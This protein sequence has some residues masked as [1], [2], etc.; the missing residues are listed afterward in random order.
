MSLSDADLLKKADGY[1][2]W[3]SDYEKNALDSMF[4]QI[5]NGRFPLT[6]KQRA[7][8]VSLIEQLE[9]RSPSSDDD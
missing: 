3:Y 1:D 4:K 2:C 8:I 7:W 5:E 9:G 6:A